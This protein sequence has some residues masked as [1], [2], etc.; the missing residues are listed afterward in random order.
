MAGSAGVDP[1]NLTGPEGPG[2]EGCWSAPTVCW[3]VLLPSCF[4]WWK[5]QLS[6]RGMVSLVGH[7]ER[8]TLGNTAREG[9][10]SPFQAKSSFNGL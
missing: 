1:V 7:F 8:Q 5:E 9:T 4:G 3:T 6:G 2:A 10:L